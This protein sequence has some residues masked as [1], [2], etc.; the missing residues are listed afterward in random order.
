MG[1]HARLRAISRRGVIRLLLLRSGLLDERP[2]A[3]PAVI[4]V[5]VWKNDA[6]VVIVML[7]A[8]QAVPRELHEAARVDGA[9][10]LQEFSAITLPPVK[11]ML[12]IMVL[13]RLIWAFNT[14]ELVFIMTEGGAGHA[15]EILT[16]V[17]FL[18]AFRGGVMGYGSS[19][20]VILLALTLVFACTYIR[21]Q[22]RTL[23]GG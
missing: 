21:A 2:L 8:L 15:T 20:D 1:Q 6:S 12:F 18:Q 4:A 5:I 13:L 10:L 19:I 11:P 9:S 14:F 7:G 17:D 23:R 22:G 3:L 16:I